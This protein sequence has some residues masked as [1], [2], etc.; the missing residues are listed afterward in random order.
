LSLKQTFRINL[1][2]K[3]QAAKTKTEETLIR[4]SNFLILI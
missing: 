4:L 2:L 1:E 3:T